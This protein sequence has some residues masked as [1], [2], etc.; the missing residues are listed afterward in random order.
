M[1]AVVALGVQQLSAAAV[2][3][4][5]D[6]TGDVAVAVL[7]RA[8]DGGDP[9][10]AAAGRPAP[11]AAAPPPPHPRAPGCGGAA[12]DSETSSATDGGVHVPVG[13][14]GERRIGGGRDGLLELTLPHL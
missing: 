8:V 10:S 4:R 2:R 9:V 1:V 11:P 5:Q 13:R 14:N 7:D 6:W 3:A 12:L